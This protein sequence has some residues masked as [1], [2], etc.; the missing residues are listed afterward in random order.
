MESIV[1]TKGDTVNIVDSSKTLDILRML[2][3]EFR[4]NVRVIFLVKDIRNYLHS[5]LKRARTFPGAGMV[6]NKSSDRLRSWLGRIVPTFLLYSWR[7]RR[8][9]LLMQNFLLHSGVPHFRLGYEEFMLKD[10]ETL[11]SLEGFLGVEKKDALAL[12]EHHILLG[13]FP[14]LSGSTQLRYDE[15]WLHSE[16]LTFPVALVA[17]TMTKVN[18]RLVYG[19]PKC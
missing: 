7:W 5:M 1:E 2:Y 9:N 19:G 8:V 4:D 11:P 14:Y 10:A 3:R 13:N 6:P 16:R 17:A 15:A 12:A 18:R